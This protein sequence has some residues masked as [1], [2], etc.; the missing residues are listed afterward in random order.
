MK[1]CATLDPL[2]RWSFYHETKPCSEVGN[3]RRLWPFGLSR[4]RKLLPGASDVVINISRIIVCL[5]S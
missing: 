2:H 3:R 1:P 4:D 5:K